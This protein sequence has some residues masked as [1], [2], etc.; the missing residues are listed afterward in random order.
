MIEKIKTFVQKKISQLIATDG[1]EDITKKKSEKQQKEKPYNYY[2]ENEAEILNRDWTKVQ[3]VKEHEKEEKRIQHNRMERIRLLNKLPILKHDIITMKDGR[4]YRVAKKMRRG[5]K[6]E[7]EV[8]LI[9][10][11]RPTNYFEKDPVEKLV[12]SSLRELTYHLEKEIEEIKEI[13]KSYDTEYE[14]VQTMDELHEEALVE[15]KRIDRLT[16]MSKLSK[17]QV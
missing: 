6:T 12:L 4:E 2:E 9:W 3:I 11:N 7:Y 1:L 14:K 16:K 15:N 13:K 17:T 8:K 5:I 10:I